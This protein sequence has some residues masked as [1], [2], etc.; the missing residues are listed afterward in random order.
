LFSGNEKSQGYFQ[1]KRPL[2]CIINGLPSGDPI[3]AQLPA[4]LCAFFE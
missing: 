3:L 1:V 2:V 4:E